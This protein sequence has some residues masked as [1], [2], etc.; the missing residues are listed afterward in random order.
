MSASVCSR[1]HRRPSELPRGTTPLCGACW[2]EW[3]SE[4]VG[5]LGGVID[6]GGVIDGKHTVYVLT[7][8]IQEGAAR[9]DHGPDQ[10]DV[11]CPVCDAT[12]TG[13]LG[14]PCAWCARRE[15][16]IVEEQRQILLSGPG[17]IAGDVELAF[18]AWRQ[19]L[20]RGNEAGLLTR[21]EVRAAWR[22]EVARH[23]A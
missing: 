17:E 21:D 2:A 11:I 6:R 15:A 13:A 14:D 12:W 5:R 23:A 16:Q 19:R 1:C 3:R 10:Y 20:L 18:E 22:R 4:L 8:A 7:G 9:P